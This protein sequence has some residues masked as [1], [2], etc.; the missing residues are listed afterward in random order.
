MRRVSEA[1]TL[2]SSVYDAVQ[3]LPE[4]WS[5]AARRFASITAV[6][7]PHGKPEIKLIYA[8]LYEQMQHFASG[9]QA[10]R[11]QVTPEDSIPPRVALFSDNNP[12][13]LI[14][15]QGILRSGAANV[16]RGAQ[17]S[18]EELIF[19]LRHSGAIAL[20]VQNIELLNKIWAGLTNLPIRFVIVLSDEP[21]AENPLKVT[22]F[23]FTYR[24][25]PPT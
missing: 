12:R 14:A 17:A 7:D 16:V 15:D 13:W 10:S 6:H 22:S 25:I 11:I 3:S 4:M 18:Y 24:P 1:P 2:K 9:V 8:Q 23:L 19:I 20:I 5:I 21:I